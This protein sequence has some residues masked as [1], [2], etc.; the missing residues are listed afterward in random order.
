MNEPAFVCGSDQPGGL[1]HS[2]MHRDTLALAWVLCIP[3]AHS[4]EEMGWDTR[5]HGLDT[6]DENRPGLS[7]VSAGRGRDG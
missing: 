7:K 4:L 6:W 1:D 5:T 2:S 3:R